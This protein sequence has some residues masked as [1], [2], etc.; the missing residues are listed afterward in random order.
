ML[1][2]FFA[3]SLPAHRHGSQSRHPSPL[4]EPVSG[5]PTERGAIAQWSKQRGAALV[6]APVPAAPVLPPLLLSSRMKRW[7]K[8][9]GSVHRPT[10][11]VAGR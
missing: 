1:C 6:E 10:G 9:M 11:K 2:G 4:Q 8:S 3:V 7:K 5:V